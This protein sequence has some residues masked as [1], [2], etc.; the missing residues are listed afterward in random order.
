MSIRQIISRFN[1]FSSSSP[2]GRELQL[3]LDTSRIYDTIPSSHVTNYPKQDTLFDQQAY[4]VRSYLQLS[5]VSLLNNLA[6]ALMKPD[7]HEHLVELTGYSLRVRDSTVEGGGRGVFVQGCVKRGQLVSLYP[8]VAYM[9]SEVRLMDGVNDYFISRYDGVVIDGASEVELDVSALGDVQTE[10][11]EHPFAVGHLINHPPQGKKP[12]VLQFMVDL[13]A[14]RLSS[15][16]RCLIPIKN[17]ETTRNTFERIEN[18]AYRERVPSASRFV[19]EGFHV[20]KTIAL[21][22]MEDLV[23]G[24]EVFMDYRFNPEIQQV[25]QWYHPCDT[26]ENSRRWWAKGMLF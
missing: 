8:G 21:V 24:D 10:H 7:L 23:E 14:R 5:S 26:D 25:P 3:R 22:A 12:N 11:L 4:V 1:P 19:Q 18:R 20:R 15:K 6:K 16:A 13:D 2:T 17:Y 9:P